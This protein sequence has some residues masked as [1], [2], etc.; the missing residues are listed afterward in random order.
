[1][2]TFLCRAPITQS[3]NALI[4]SGL[5]IT[6]S[7]IGLYSLV[8]SLG[9]VEVGWKGTTMSVLKN[10]LVTNLELEEGLLVKETLQVM[11]HLVLFIMSHSLIATDWKQPIAIKL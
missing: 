2:C 10:A 5:G 11:M 4:F 3:L 9:Q 6:M 1:M 7:A 8:M